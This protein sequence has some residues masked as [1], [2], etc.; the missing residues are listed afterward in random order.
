MEASWNVGLYSTVAQQLHGQVFHAHVRNTLIYHVVLCKDGSTLSVG[1]GGIGVVAGVVYKDV[2]TLLRTGKDVVVQLDGG[3]Y[4]K[5]CTCH[6]HSETGGAHC[7]VLT[8]QH[9]V[10]REVHL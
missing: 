6:H 1:D 9:Q 10:V 3:T 5:V 4:R 8:Q 7:L 2:D